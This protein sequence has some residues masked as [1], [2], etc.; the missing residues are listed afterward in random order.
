MTQIPIKKTRK[1]KRKSK[2]RKMRVV[3]KTLK[4]RT[5]LKMLLSNLI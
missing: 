5:L 1:R 3:I 2:I 4:K